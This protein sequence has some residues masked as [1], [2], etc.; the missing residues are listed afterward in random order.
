MAILKIMRNLNLLVLFLGV[1]FMYVMGCS[2]NEGR[3]IENSNN[4]PLSQ[5]PTMNFSWS[6]TLVAREIHLTTEKPI[7]AETKIQLVSVDN[8]LFTVIRLKSG[9]LASGK[10]GDFFSCK[11]FGSSNLQLV[12]ASPIGVIEMRYMW[13]EPEGIELDTPTKAP[14]LNSTRQP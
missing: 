14:E 1:Q 10:P 5:G 6:E 8:N 9:E 2:S 4:L 7:D 13:S 3:N 12:A 11:Q